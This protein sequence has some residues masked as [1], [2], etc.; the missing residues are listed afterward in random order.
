MK[1]PLRILLGFAAG[2]AIVAVCAS[3]F[4]ARATGAGT[5]YFV[6]A[7]ADRGGDIYVER[8]A[9]CHGPHLNDGQ[10]GRQL[11]GAAFRR[12]WGGKSLADLVA[13]ME[14]EMPPGQ[15]GELSAEDYADV[16][17]YMLA[18]NG[19]APSAQPLPSDA[20]GLKPLLVPTN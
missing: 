5:P 16:T 1:Q 8:C 6:Q 3:G 7:Q 20:A 9:A 18:A 2:A 17:A 10:W 12:D 19:I 13:Y 4:Q 11:K 15:V 14:K